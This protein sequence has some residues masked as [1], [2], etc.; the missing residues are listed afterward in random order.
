MEQ[1]GAVPLAAL[2]QVTATVFAHQNGDT[3]IGK[4][5]R[6]KKRANA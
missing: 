5:T 6:M 1:I 2:V 3:S 4:P